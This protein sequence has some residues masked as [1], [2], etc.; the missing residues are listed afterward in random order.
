MTE[1]EKIIAAI[2]PFGLPYAP[3]IYEGGEERFF[4]Y[5]YADERAVLYADNTPKVVVASVQVHLY[6]PAEENFISLKNKVRRALHRQGFTY[7]EVTVMREDK[8]RH[9]VFECDVEEEME[10]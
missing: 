10:D 5:N 6:L 4:V 9:I 1:F 8:K 7:P 3:D 2:K